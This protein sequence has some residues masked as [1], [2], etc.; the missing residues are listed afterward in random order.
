MRLLYCIVAQT[1]F[2][3]AFKASLLSLMKW[4][5]YWSGCLIAVITVVLPRLP[6]FQTTDASDALVNPGWTAQRKLAAREKTRDLWYHGFDNYMT[7]AFPMDEVRPCQG[8]DW[9]NPANI[10]RNDVAG[11]FSLTLVDVLDSFVIL[12]DRPGFE[13]A[14]KKVIE[15]VSFDVNTKPQVF[16]T[17]I[18][19]LGGLLSGHLYASQPDQPF[20]LPWYRGQ[21]LELAYDLGDR[22]LP[23]F[24]TP[25]G[26]PYARINLR[27]GIMKGETTETCTA[28]AGSLILEF[29]LLSR[30][31]GDDRFEK[32]A[33]KAYFGI[34]NRRS[35]LGIVGNTINSWNGQW[36]PPE[37]S[38]IG[39]GVDSFYEY[40]LK[41]YIMSGEIEFLDIWDD[42]YAAIMR[43][44]RSLDGYWYRPVNM[45]TG[46]LAYYTVDS[47][48]AF[49][50]GLQVLAGDVEAAI[51]LHM[52]YY[53]LWKH[54][55]GLP[56]VYDTSF[57][58]ATSHQYPLRPEFIESTW[59]LYRATKDPFYLDVGERVLFDLTTRAKVPCGL[60]GIA[61]LRSNKRDDRMESFALSET[62]KYLYLLFDEDNA[63]HRDD[64]DFVLTT[65]G[66]IFKLPEVLKR[67]SPP[68][69]R[70]FISHQ[71]PAY[72]PQEKG[73][74]LPGLLQGVRYRP[75]VEYARSLVGASASETDK[76]WW[77]A[78]GWCEK[79]KLD[80]YSYEF[81]LSVNGGTVPE[82]PSPSLK[83]L[84]VVS[85]GFVINNVTGIRTKIVQRMD[86]KGFDVRKLGPY[87][88]RPGQVVYINDTELFA[89][90]ANGQ[91]AQTAIWDRDRTVDLHFMDFDTLSPQSTLE[92]D[93]NVPR[94][95]DV[96]VVVTAS[97]AQF[98]AHFLD[99]VKSETSSAPEYLPIFYDKD[100][101]RGCEP[102]QY[103]YPAF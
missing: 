84:D 99:V 3:K 45:N 98:G 97:T 15:H 93:S 100:N 57:K 85:D 7:H 2:S 68:P 8:P 86:G 52:L 44:S 55:A 10:A 30:L 31:T 6:L 61:D 5:S 74:K 60:T 25:T 101:D 53:N 50:P 34:W 17:T 95:A 94:P 103:S 77:S 23:A 51:K 89:S 88:V 1:K 40:A 41:W 76:K 46:D 65:E 33:K 26:I 14:V 64:S 29:G 81:I 18:R 24:S 27:Q 96:D 37:V 80:V 90:P 73:S 70:K 59:Y 71:C 19:V 102:Y 21:L 39:A 35:D 36:T 92:S 13:L 38:G 54:H 75:H 72:S 58:V 49:W 42:A 20:Y 78:D 48:S 82:D 56:E 32:A 62:L 83:K 91:L 4:E 22:L 9:N 87:N 28:G 69:S 66:H 67:A 11:N 16:E 47:L 43:Y 63:L 79:P 12:D